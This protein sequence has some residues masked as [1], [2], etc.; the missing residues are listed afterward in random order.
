MLQNIKNLISDEIDD[1]NL[2]DINSDFYSYGNSYFNFGFDTFITNENLI[3]ELFLT[4]KKFSKN[5]FIKFNKIRQADI[6]WENLFIKN[7]PISE[8]C[9]EV[10][11]IL[12]LLNINVNKN[13]NLIRLKFNSNIFNIDSNDINELSYNYYIKYLFNKSKIKYTIM[14]FNIFSD[15]DIDKWEN[16][17]EKNPYIKISFNI[18]QLFL[19]L[20]KSYNFIEEN[21]F[22][23]SIMGIKQYI[24]YWKNIINPKYF[25][26][27][28]ETNKIYTYKLIINEIVI[29]LSKNINLPIALNFVNNG[30]FDEIQ[31]INDNILSLEFI[32][33]LCKNNKDCKFI[34]M[35]SYPINYNTLYEYQN[36]FSNLYIFDNTLSLKK[37]NL[38]ELILKKKIDNLGINFTTFIGFNKTPEQC[39]YKSFILKKIIKEYLY[40][41]YTELENIGLDISI[42]QIKKDI[43]ILLKGN[44]EEFIEY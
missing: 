18:D 9:K 39:L 37:T 27:T 17:L 15:Y 28:I 35:F 32:E 44:F 1:T 3:N 2:I 31:K 36:K 14:N 29:P 20:K 30:K 40:E 7:T 43:S 34:A 8:A 19:N 10:L 16:N 11:I 24:S 42:N 25:F 13:L 21:G 12:N 41:K 22:F 26:I 4:Y 5:E 23:P 33:M 38:L 6:I